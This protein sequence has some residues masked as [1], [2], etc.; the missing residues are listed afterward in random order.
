MGPT[1]TQRN[2]VYQTWITVNG[3]SGKTVKAVSWNWK[4][5]TGCAVYMGGIGGG[6]T[7]CAMQNPQPSNMQVFLCK[8]GGACLNITGQQ[9]GTSS[10]WNGQTFTNQGFTL[11][12]AVNGMGPLTP[13][14]YG[15]MHYVTVTY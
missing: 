9:T 4:F 1:M 5:N 6:S 11:M 7:Q 13:V 10:L 8:N 14:A 3:P 12:F 2:S 15:Q